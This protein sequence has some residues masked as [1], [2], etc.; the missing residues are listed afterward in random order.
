[1]FKTWCDK[2]CVEHV[3]RTCRVSQTTVQKYRKRDEWEKRLQDAQARLHEKLADKIAG[4]KAEMF[5]MLKAVSRKVLLRIIGE[6]AK[7]KSG[8]DIQDYATVCKMQLLLMGEP[9]S[10]VEHGTFDHL[11][12]EQVQALYEQLN[13]DGPADIAIRELEAKCSAAKPKGP[14]AAS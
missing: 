13:G 2:Q 10:R 9:E 12:D 4:E 3:A 5:K 11:T 1:M 14:E 6:G 8:N 7:H